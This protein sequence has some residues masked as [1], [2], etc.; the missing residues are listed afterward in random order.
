VSSTIYTIMLQL[1]SI[2]TVML[3]MDGTRILDPISGIPIPSYTNDHIMSFARAWTGFEFQSN[4][5]NIEIYSTSN[6]RIDPM[7]IIPDWRDVFP[8]INLSGGYIGDTYPLCVDIPDNFFLQK[9]AKYRLLGSSTVLELQSN[10]S[11]TVNASTTSLTLSSRSQLYAKLCDPVMARG[12]KCRLQNEVVLDENIVC[13]GLECKVDTLRLVQ[14]T[15][16]VYFEYVE[17]PCVKF[18]FYKNAKKI[19]TSMNTEAMCANPREIAAGEA[20]CATSNTTSQAR[21]CEYSG[22]RM[23]FDLA[24]NRCEHIGQSLCEFTVMEACSSDCCLSNEYYFWHDTSCNLQVK[25]DE[26]GHA[27]IVHNPQN[28]D[29]ELVHVDY[30][31][32]SSYFFPVY[33][34]EG[35]PSVSNECGTGICEMID[36]SCLCNI[37]VIDSSVFDS[38]PKNID[39]ILFRLHVGSFSPKT[40]ESSTSRFPVLNRLKESITAHFCKQSASYDENTIFEVKR[41]G[42]DIKYLKNVQSVVKI[43]DMNGE[44]TDFSFRNPPHFMNMIEPEIRDAQYETDAVLND[45][46][47]HPN[48]APFLAKYFIQ[49]F[50]HSN[51]S[52]RYIQVVATAFVNGSYGESFGSGQYGDLGAMVAAVLLDREARSAVASMDPTSGSLREPILKLIGY[53]RSM[54]LVT[55]DKYP[56]IELQDIGLKI[57]QMAHEIDSVFSFFEQDFATAGPVKDASL[58]APEGRRY[59]SR[60][61]IGLLNGLYSMTE[62]GLTSCKQG[63]GIK[64]G[65]N[66]FCVQGDVST[67][68]AR[69]TYSPTE[70]NNA[71]KVVDELAT[72]L[73]AGRL[74]SESRLVIQNEYENALNNDSGLRLAQQL[75]ASTPE[76]HSTSNIEFSNEERKNA[77]ERVMLKKPSFKSLVYLYLNGGVDSFNMLVPHSGCKNKDMFAEYS[78]VRG[79]IALPKEALLTIEVKDDSQECNT[80][81]IHPSLSVLQNLYTDGDAVFFANTGV[82]FEPVTKSDWEVKTK[83]QLFAHNIQ[84]KEAQFVDA[85][86]MVRGT[87][88]LGRIGDRLTKLGYDTGSFS[89]TDDVK[90]LIGQ[91]K[92]PFVLGPRGVLPYRSPSSDSFFPSMYNMKEENNLRSGIFGKT[93]LDIFLKAKEETEHS[94]FAL[95]EVETLNAFPASDIGNQL[96]TASETI[97]GRH[98]LNNER[99]IFMANMNGFDTHTDVSINIKNKFDELNE[100]L[101]SFVNEMKSLGVWDDVILLISSDFGRGMPPNSSGGT[102]HGWGGNY[103]AIGGGLKGGRILGKYP[104]DLSENGSDV[105]SQGRVIPTTSWDSIMN[106][107]A[108]WIG[109]SDEQDLDYAVPGRKRFLND[110]FDNNDL[111]GNLQKSND[112]YMKKKNT[113]TYNSYDLFHGGANGKRMLRNR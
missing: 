4:R 35:F 41:D 90:A 87:G 83:T 44:T 5:G 68:R 110:L 77:Q 62:F 96:K 23:T 38:M 8:K 81:G 25:V 86:Q 82:L 24:S 89:L 106:G 21:N 14:V 65:S 13:D 54:E 95:A 66:E 60:T 32:N 69:L 61:I 72:V 48:T 109:L 6:N 113:K 52:P 58:V 76:F 57:G 31:S 55:F 47:Y 1:F 37:E 88:V 33:W 59:D 97:Q 30:Q 104:S 53:M 12:S 9:G 70:P 17:P 2:G 26:S 63:F 85:H 49:R 29:E 75:I 84:K 80:F 111:F 79:E 10:P 42:E 40:L 50:G 16:T 3:N 27:A 18:A 98:A 112:A 107:I 56:K 105:L 51:P 20:C 74:N 100:A 15:D 67:A 102:N 39:E 28:T 108:M 94:Y 7:Q 43:V 22:E 73:T 45:Y 78:S 46:F 101:S 36:G 92:R 103:F 71:K 93:W 19:S 34:D 91:N 11:S 64:N 99:Q